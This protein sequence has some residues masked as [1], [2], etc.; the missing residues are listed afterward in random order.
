MPRNVDPEFGKLPNIQL[1]DIDSLQNIY[2]RDAVN[3][4]SIKNDLI[5]AEKIISKGLE[6]FYNELSNEEID[7][8]IKDLKE[9]V[10]KARTDKLAEHLNGKNTYTKEEVDYI[11][12][13]IL[14]T[15]FHAPL[16]DL[17]NPDYKDEK[18]QILRDLF[19]L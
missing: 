12:K 5:S 17:R 2:S 3:R 6:G 11:T 10:E 7:F 13:N 19:G 4:V 14:N 8:L 1:F 15:I 18:I 16:K 9:K